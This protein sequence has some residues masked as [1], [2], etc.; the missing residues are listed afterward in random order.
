MKSECP[1]PE[2]A[3]SRLLVLTGDSCFLI[4]SA[5]DIRISS[6]P[7]GVGWFVVMT[8]PSSRRDGG[9]AAASAALA[10]ALAG[11]H[12]CHRDELTPLKKPPGEGERFLNSNFL[13]RRL[14]LNRQCRMTNDQ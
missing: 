9:S 2:Q 6:F 4:L 11:Q 1:K 13:I 10:G 3:S 12:L 14:W 5:F 8:G 7:N